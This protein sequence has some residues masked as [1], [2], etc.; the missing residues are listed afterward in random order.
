MSLQS[1]TR[2]FQSYFSCVSI[3]RAA[4]QIVI[5][6]KHCIYDSLAACIQGDSDVISSCHIYASCFPAMM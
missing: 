3:F 5:A 6:A 4:T 2:V 1:E